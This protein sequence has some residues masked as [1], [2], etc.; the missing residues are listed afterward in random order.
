MLNVQI[1]CI[2]LDEMQCA[3]PIWFDVNGKKH[4]ELPEEL[5]DLTEGEK[6]LIQIINVYVPVHHLFKGQTGCK[7]HSAAFRQDITKVASILP[8]LAEDVGICPSNK[9][10]KMQKEILEKRNSFFERMWSLLL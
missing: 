7:G 2:F 1:I 4:F 10:F 6:L 3:L 5:K 8:N 9:K